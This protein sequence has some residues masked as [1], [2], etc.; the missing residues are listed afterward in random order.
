MEVREKSKEKKGR[1]KHYRYIDGQLYARVVY[2]DESGK[3]VE[4]HYK[5][6]SKTH[7][8][9]I[10]QQ[11]LRELSEHGQQMLDTDRMTF[12]E[13]AGVYEER[14]LIP[15]EYHQ[16]R[17]TA[18]LRS[19]KSAKVFLSVLVDFFG[20]RRI[21]SITHSDVEKFRRDRLKTKTVRGTERSITSVNRELELLRAM[22]NFAQREG[23][24]VRTPF[25]SGAP[26][27]SKADETHR[28]R[29]LSREEEERLLAACAGK[30]AHLR[31]LLIAALDTGC[32]RGELLQLTWQDVDFEGRTIRIRA[33]TTKTQRS[34]V[35]P[36]SNRLLEELTSLYQA[37][38]EAHEIIFGVKTDVKRSFTAACRAA[39]IDDFHFHDCRHTAITRMIRAGV[40][41]ALVMK[42]SG[43]TQMQTFTRYVNT[44]SDALRSAAT[45]LDAFQANGAVHD[46]AELER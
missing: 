22:L 10:H 18:G 36:I 2:R 8:R 40:P 14:K 44:D 39:E 33:T 41:P 17:K 21:R 38:A 45:A 30:R 1:D 19:L 34:R 43:H 4:R 35:I 15:A 25:N 32:R 31:P 46:P 12:A 6:E 20:A 5:A 37:T 16:D 7:A 26:L 11:K 24:L 13:L 27:I 3:R 29:V 9:E 23:W 42:I 28:D